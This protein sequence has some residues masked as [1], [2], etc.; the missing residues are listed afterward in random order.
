MWYLIYINSLANLRKTVMTPETC[1][2]NLY[3]YIYIYK[4]AF[5]NLPFTI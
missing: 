4:F 1:T 5:I 3:T 2:L